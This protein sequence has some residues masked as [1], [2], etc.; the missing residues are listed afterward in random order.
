[1]KLSELLWGGDV[2][3]RLPFNSHRS[4]LIPGA[5][6]IWWLMRN[7]PKHRSDDVAASIANNGE[8]HSYS[9]AAC[10]FSRW[11]PIWI[12]TIELFR[13]SPVESRRVREFRT[14]RVGVSF[15]RAS[16]RDR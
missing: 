3:E 1:M 13:S 12:S 9:R 7:V 2:L 14:L 15:P 11:L 16:P 6:L 4:R 8:L 5:A 10:D